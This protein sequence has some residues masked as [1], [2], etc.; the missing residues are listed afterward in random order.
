ML[1]L[2]HI[3]IGRRTTARKESFTGASRVDPYHTR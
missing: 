1:R 2:R 3:I